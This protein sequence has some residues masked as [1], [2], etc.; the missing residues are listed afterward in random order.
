MWRRKPLFEKN[1]PPSLGKGRAA[2]PPKAPGKAPGVTPARQTSKLL[3]LQSENELLKGKVRLLEEQVS[4]G[5]AQLVAV[6]REREKAD[7]LL[8]ER[9]S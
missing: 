2:A 7:A 4:D 6:H 1:L 9:D 5:D 8:K 3:R